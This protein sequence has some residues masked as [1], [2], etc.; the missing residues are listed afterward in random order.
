MLTVANIHRAALQ[1]VSFSLADG[2]CL[3]V[4]GPSGSGKSTLLRA[5]ADL[6]PNAGEVRLD[7]ALRESMPAPHWRRRVIYVAAE[8]GW[9][10]DTPAEHFPSLDEAAEL[11]RA[12]GLAPDLL[13]RP[14]VQL[15]T[16]ERQRL[17]LAR[18]LA[19]APRALLL[20]EPTAALDAGSRE[21]AEALI[22]ARRQKGLC[23]LWVTHDP[24]QAARVAQNFLLLEKGAARAAAA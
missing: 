4:R 8:P 20:D 12:L 9:W 5:I 14:I 3:A 18:A 24:E 19:R 23:V 2:A 11:A 6:D 1:P 15:S 21:L 16:G 10:A 17:A 22:A 7:G 13:A